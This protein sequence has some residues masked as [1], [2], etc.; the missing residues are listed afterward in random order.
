MGTEF[1]IVK[2]TEAESRMEVNKDWRGRE[3]VAE[4]YRA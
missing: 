4:R 2:L 1:K 3:R